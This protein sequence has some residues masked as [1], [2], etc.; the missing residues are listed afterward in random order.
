MDPQYYNFILA[1]SVDSYNGYSFY[2]ETMVDS[3]SE[4]SITISGAV[5]SGMHIT[6][7][8]FL[9]TEK[10]PADFLLD[11]TKLF[12]LYFIKDVGSKTIKICSRNTFFTGRI[13]D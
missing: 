3:T 9:K 2:A 10:S 11:Y 1:P 7:Q 6:K 5:T 4:G 13:N 12:G 8:L